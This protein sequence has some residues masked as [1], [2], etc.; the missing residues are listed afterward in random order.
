MLAG[1]IIM[2]KP[3]GRRVHLL[4]RMWDAWLRVARWPALS[5]GDPGLDSVPPAEAAVERN[6]IRVARVRMRRYH[7]LDSTATYAVD[8]DFFY[9]C[10][11]CMHSGVNVED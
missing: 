2:M 4:W 5:S 8:A 7:V 9:D 1:Y 11:D 6:R 10:Y 3:P